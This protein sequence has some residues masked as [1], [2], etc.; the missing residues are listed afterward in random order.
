MARLAERAFVDAGK[1]DGAPRQSL[2]APLT[3][4]KARSDRANLDLFGF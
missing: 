1:R 3:Q 2:N 4:R